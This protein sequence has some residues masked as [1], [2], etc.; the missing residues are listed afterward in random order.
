MALKPARKYDEGTEIS[1][2]M[3]EPA[4]RGIAVVNCPDAS[5]V[6][7][8]MDDPNATVCIPDASGEG[9]AVGMLLNDVVDLDESR[10]CRNPHRDETTVCGKVTVLTH[11]WA[12]TN[13]IASGVNPS[14]GDKAY[15]VA[16]G[17]WTNQDTGDDSAGY[18]MSAKDS[19]GYAKVAVKTL[20]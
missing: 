18:F 3:N 5:G 15:Y 12:V 11:G 14:A 2:F 17:L 10:C 9:P 20:V 13:M 19:D 7:A 8:A 16:G 1:Y 4:E 6:G